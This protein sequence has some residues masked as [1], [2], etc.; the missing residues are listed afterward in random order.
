MKFESRPSFKLLLRRLFTAIFSSLC[1][2]L[3]NAVPPDYVEA[4][5]FNLRKLKVNQLKA[6]LEK[7]GMKSTGLKP[8]LLKRLEKVGDIV[9]GYELSWITI[10]CIKLKQALK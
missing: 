6:N 4:T 10:F 9:R 2:S 7:R 1:F 8:L 3:G 5:L